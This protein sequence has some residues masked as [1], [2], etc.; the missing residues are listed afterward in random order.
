MLYF[1]YDNK[2]GKS[3]TKARKLF[4]DLKQKKPDATFVE[5]DEHSASVLELSELIESQ[6][7]FETKIVCLLKNISLNKE[8]E[9]E[10]K[11]LVT[12][13][14]DA[15]SVFIWLETSLKKAELEL[16]ESKATKSFLEKEVVK[17]KK[18]EV[19]VFKLAE[20]F[21]AR[22]KKNGWR[23]LL[24]L[25]KGGVAAE[26]VH[27]ILWWQ[28]KSILLTFNAKTAEETGLKPFVFSKAK[29]FAKNFN[30]SQLQEYADRLVRMYHDAHR[31]K[32]D[33]YNELEVLLLEL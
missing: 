4:N 15:S 1:F 27:G 28:L 26:E 22:D 9:K 3:L 23:F 8:I 24:E 5:L 30:E 21:G 2:T 32:G 18:V 13:V 33:L 10:M 20:Y 12:S 31:G 7:L 14:A 17:E 6:G 25:K 11:R 29:G 19:N 16:L